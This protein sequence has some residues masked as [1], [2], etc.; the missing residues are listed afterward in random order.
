MNITL[1]LSQ[2]LPGTTIWTDEHRNYGCLR[3]YDHV[4]DTIVHKYRF[5][6]Y[7]IGV[8]IQT[9]EFFNSGIKMEIKKRKR[10]R[11]EKR[12]QFLNNYCFV[13]NDKKNLLKAIIELL[14]C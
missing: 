2:V 8:N 9:V 13:F 4:H 5:L 10:V 14:K 11:T 7:E 3:D 6:I 1:I 12:Q